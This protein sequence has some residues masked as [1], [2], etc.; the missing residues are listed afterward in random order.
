VMGELSAALNRETI[1]IDES[2]V[3][4]ENFAGLVKRIADDTISGNTAKKVFEAMWAGEGSAD[5]VIEA[6][7]LKQI[8]DTGALEGIIDE[9]IANSPQ[10]VE[11]YRNA[12]PDKRGKMIGFFMG[13]VMKATQ[14]KANP[15]Q[16]TKLLNEKLLN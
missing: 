3:D 8:S 7:G 2:P 1:G 14:G 9:V 13:Q 5:E 15:G 6:K 10:Q 16:V 11:N 12:E 4:A